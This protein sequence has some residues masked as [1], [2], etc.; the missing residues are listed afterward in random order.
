MAGNAEIEKDGQVYHV[1]LHRTK[2]AKPW[3]SSRPTT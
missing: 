1:K 2:K 3:R